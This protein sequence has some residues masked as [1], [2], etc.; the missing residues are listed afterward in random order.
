[1]AA[2]WLKFTW[3]LSELPE[4]AGD[5]THPL[6]LRAADREE[7]SAVLKTVLTSFSMDTGWAD[8]HKPLMQKLTGRIDEAFDEKEP[9]CIVL[10]YGHRI[11]GSSVLALAEDEQEPN[12]I[13]GPC[14]VH[15]YRSRGYGA[16]LLGASLLHLKKAGVRRAIGLTRERT[17]AA[18]FLYPH[19][20][21]TSTPWD[22]DVLAPS[23]KLAA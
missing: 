7:K 5:I 19:F 13:T 9:A 23:P 14:V 11:I 1:M 20:G 18:R 10:Q 3:D 16:S 2:K 8:I 22:A 21:G 6:I 15:E 4:S 12:L 17:V